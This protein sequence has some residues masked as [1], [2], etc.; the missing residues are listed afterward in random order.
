MNSWAWGWFGTQSVLD[1]RFG[2]RA[3]AWGWIGKSD[4]IEFLGLGLGFFAGLGYGINLYGI[5]KLRA[6]KSC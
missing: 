5:P 4:Q 6:G 2:G 1:P 3:G